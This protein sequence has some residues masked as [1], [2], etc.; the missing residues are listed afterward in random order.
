MIIDS[1]VNLPYAI[2]ET[3]AALKQ[4]GVAVVPFNVAY[5]LVGQTPA[6]IQRIFELKGRPP[7]KSCVVLGNPDIFRELAHPKN[8]GKIGF[9]KPVGL[10]TRINVSSLFIPLL[11]DTVRVRDTV[12]IFLNMGEFGEPLA[13]MAFEQGGLVFGSSANRSG[14]GNHFHF[15]NV[16]R[17]IVDHATISI[18]GGATAFSTLRPDGKGV[19]STILDLEKGIVVRDGLECAEIVREARA[20]GI[21]I[22]NYP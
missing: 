10:V 13:A 3:H 19:G 16:E 9:T 2:R 5:A 20:M 18:N 1:T 8:H 11:S 12:A 4:G 15:S 17:E 14:N 22:R 7:E 21:T 6:A